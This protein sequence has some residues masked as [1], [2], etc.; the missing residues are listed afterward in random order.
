M[1]Y[2]SFY[3]D[4]T[5]YYV[6][7]HKKFKYFCVIYLSD[8]S[9]LVIKMGKYPYSFGEAV[10]YSSV[11]LITLWWIPVLGPIIIGYI[12]G[13]KSGGPIKGLVAMAIPIILYLM[14]V[15]AIQAGLINIPQNLSSY[16]HGTILTTT[17]ALPFMG[18]IENTINVATN[19][20]T[21]IESYLYYA[22]PSFFIMLS[23]AFIGG[24]VSRQIILEKGI[25]KNISKRDSPDEDKGEQQEIPKRAPQPYNPYPEQY[26]LP[27]QPQSYP[28][29]PQ[30]QMAQNQAYGNPNYAP[31]QNY[32]GQYPNMEPTMMQKNNVEDNIV[33]IHNKVTKPR[34]RKSKKKIKEF[35][36]E[37]NKFV[38]HPMDTKKNI[39]IK[40]KKINN[41]HSIAF[42]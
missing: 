25:W 9:Q 22:P 42:L 7:F 32:Y 15:Q 38:V 5:A 41:E 40:R 10:I 17:A 3:L 21:H 4:F 14:V 18:Y 34:R 26:A 19:V 36:V 31:P 20:G 24:A 35:E 16:V 37:N 2:F 29:Y 8:K 1:N 33:T 28:A 30:M 11:L 39:A 13:R 6:V 23:F 12:T 27:V